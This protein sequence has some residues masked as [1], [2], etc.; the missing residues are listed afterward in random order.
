M[1]L[2]NNPNSY[3]KEPEEKN[4]NHIIIKNDS[5]EDSIDYSDKFNKILTDNCENENRLKNNMNNNTYFNF[6]DNKKNEIINEPE[7][8]DNIN[9]NYNSDF[10]AAFG[11]NVNKNNFYTLYYRDEIDERLDKYKN[12]PKLELDYKQNLREQLGIIFNLENIINQKLFSVQRQ[13]ENN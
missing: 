5:S 2:Y 4:Q 7:F 12:C 10:F 1:Y 3:Q 13:L 9:Y 8:N 11:N 6:E